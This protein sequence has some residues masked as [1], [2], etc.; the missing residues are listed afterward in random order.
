MFFPPAKLDNEWL[1]SHWGGLAEVGKVDIRFLWLFLSAL[2]REAGLYREMSRF[3]AGFWQTGA[4]AKGF[5]V[6]FGDL[7]ASTCA[8]LNSR[9]LETFKYVPG[10]AITNRATP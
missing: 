8:L 7:G 1:R 9:C 2:V 3:G 6:G 4:G 10:D 5:H